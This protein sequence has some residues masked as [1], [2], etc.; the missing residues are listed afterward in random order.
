MSNI[1]LNI[2]GEN[3]QE[4]YSWYLEGRLAVNRRYQRKLVW[5]R[6]EKQHLID[7]IT[8]KFPLPLV[9]LAE[10]H[11]NGV[12]KY[13]IIDGMQRLNAIFGFVENQFDYRGEYFDLETMA[14]SKQLLDERKLTQHQNVLAR[15]VCAS[16]A[17][18]KIP[19]STYRIDQTDDIDEIFR[20]INSYGR[21]LSDQEIRQ[22]GVTGPFA[23]LVR[24]LST[25]IRGDV[26]H[27]DVLLLSKMGAISIAKDDRD[28]GIPAG[29]IFWV[30]QGVL[31]KEDIRDSRDEEVISDLISYIVSP[32]TDK[33]ASSR[34]ARDEIYGRSRDSEHHSLARVAAKKVEMDSRVSRF[35][36]MVLEKT[37][38]QAID[39]FDLLFPSPNGFKTLLKR[40]SVRYGTPRY[41]QVVFLAIYEL[42]FEEKLSLVNS[43][44]LIKALQGVD[45]TVDISTGGNWA[46]ANRTKNIDVVKGL[47]RRNFKRN[48]S[49]PI[50]QIGRTEFLNLV[51]KSK[52]EASSYDFK[53]G[54][55]RLDDARSFDDACFHGVLAT[56]CAMANLGKDKVGY[57]VLGVA[58]KQSDADRIKKIDKI[59]ATKI[60]SY[61]MVGIDRE[62]TKFHT[63]IDKYLQFI[64]D[65]ISRS[66]LS[67]EIRLRVTG[68][69]TPIDFDGKTALVIRVEAGKEPCF[70]ADT[71]YRR[72]GAQTVSVSAKEIIQIARFF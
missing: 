40:G 6:E 70:L 56:I 8:R 18:Y 29:D 63:N 19:I 38:Q 12:A 71:A 37:I 55:H 64:S 1:D 68:Q 32:E 2:R 39:I 20:R 48:A 13:E 67:D 69:L 59:G 43:T 41:F 72:N 58:D 66:E 51:T 11:I 16:I 35:G 4:L 24:T 17:N 44:G 57:V 50:A 15:A 65:K 25:A 3:I 62:A 61:Y 46:A 60:G 30:R 31:L 53:Q 14:S 5:T 45:T 7:T 49:D 52:T 21:V 28:E 34:Q 54:L 27:E 33:P 26:S 36:A 42:L 22:A 9:L 47:I 10:V 23:D